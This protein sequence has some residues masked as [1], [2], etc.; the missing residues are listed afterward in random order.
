MST[1]NTQ[2]K[3]NARKEQA[4]KLLVELHDVFTSQAAS[5]ILGSKERID[6]AQLMSNVGLKV[7]CGFVK[8]NTGKYSS[9][10][11][12]RYLR[13]RQRRVPHRS[14]IILHGNNV[15][16][17]DSNFTWAGESF[18]TTYHNIVILNRYALRY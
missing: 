13:L 4:E 8:D 6:E 3:L 1:D 17:N 18:V 9:K 12:S 10:R 16:I 15:D 11:D 14:A 5:T 2:D 7:C